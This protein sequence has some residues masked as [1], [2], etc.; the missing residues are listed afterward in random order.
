MANPVPRPALATAVLLAGLAPTLVAA[1][2][3]PAVFDVAA[4]DAYVA[5]QVRDRGYP[6]L[7]LAIAVDG[8]IVL[9]K[10]YGKRNL[11]ENLP[12]G[13]ETAFSVGSVTKQFTCAAVLLLAQEGKLS[14]DDP[15]SK[16]VPGLTRG[17]DITL[18]DLM[19]HASG[20]PDFYP[21]DFVVRQ[22]REP[23]GV[24][25]LIRQ[26]A[27]APLDFEPGSRY[28]YSNTG[29]VLLGRVIEKASGEPFH[30]FVGRRILQPLGLGHSE[31]DPAAG[32]ADKATGYTTIALGPPQPAHRE[33]SGW[34]YAAGDLWAS[35][36][37]LVRWD[38]ALLGG[39][40]MRPESLRLMTAPRML[41][42]GPTRNYGC[43]LAS[44]RREGEVVLSHS[45]GLS[46]Y[47]SYNAMVPRTRSAV[48]LLANSEYLDPAT[49][50]G[51]ILDL[52]IK[53]HRLDDQAPSV[54]TVDGPKPR[55]AALAFFRQI[56]AGTVDRSTL[57]DEFSAYLPDPVLQGARERFGPLGEPTEITEQP[58]SERGGFE[59]TPLTFK[60]AGGTAL[61]G[62]LYRSRDGK[63]QQ[64]LFIKG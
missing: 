35:A 45:G 29:Y 13:P 2:Q 34:I 48:V 57:S 47:Q 16:Y 21:L 24:D 4:V 49:L 5:S 7:A 40:V 3:P 38:L 33:G 17:N 56:Q 44:A 59:V 26:Y 28:S 25:D 64:L 36:A 27:G 15:V 30:A 32:L 61:K 58:S 60:F 52:V 6:G 53:S 46:G 20:Y 1:D 51:T 18:Y 23:I 54:P 42:A 43:G 12:V 39:K 9:S 14:V 22:M 11:A 10:G 19:T 55:E 8:E 50:H 37:D 62:L 41:P 31:F 63:I